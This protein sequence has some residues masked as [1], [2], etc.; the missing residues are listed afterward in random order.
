MTGANVTVVG[1]RAIA[2][3][4][5]PAN[6][7]LMVVM[8][9]IIAM[10]THPEPGLQPPS[11]TLTRPIGTPLNLYG[12]VA[13]N[14][15]GEGD[16]L[17]LTDTSKGLRPPVVRDVVEIVADAADAA[18]RWTPAATRVTA[19]AV[20]PA[21]AAVVTA[22]LGATAA[23]RPAAAVLGAAALGLVAV[24]RAVK[25]R[26][27]PRPAFLLATAVVILGA[28]TG[29]QLA[30]LLPATG[31]DRWQPAGWMLVC[32]A[33]GAV[34]ATVAAYWAVQTSGFVVAATAFAAAVAGACGAALWAGA[35]PGAVA[36]VAG[37]V[38]ILSF[39]ALPTLATALGRVL[40]IAG[41]AGAQDAASVRARVTSARGYL[42]ALA[43]TGAV[44]ATAAATVLAG[45]GGGW[46]I[47]LALL[48]TAAQLLVARSFSA[49][50]QVLVVVVAGFAGLLSTAV[51]VAVTYTVDPIVV[52]APVLTGVA[53]CLA[54]TLLRLSPESQTQ[55]KRWL[56]RLELAV[57]FVCPIAILGVLGVYQLISRVLT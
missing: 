38:V 15:L 36:A 53:V 56:G 47:T 5:L 39:G 25:G 41:A 27:E 40:G 20:V 12:T 42:T 7:P 57:L 10:L 29:W 31:G 32:T 4:T 49:T 11:W 45:T 35:A 50:A 1:P 23:P 34:V 30:R 22:L 18:R 9:E 46:A 55:V 6:V 3:L 43:G 2:D 37:Y 33:A 26:W 24:L 16:V 8:P 17:T 21:A 48:F 51:I 44:L 52:A 13:D 28:G 19:A 14:L 54:I